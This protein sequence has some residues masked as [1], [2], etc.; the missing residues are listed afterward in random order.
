MR[1]IPN[2][3]CQV[4]QGSDAADFLGGKG[5]KKTDIVILGSS[6]YEQPGM[7]DYIDR[8]CLSSVCIVHRN[9]VK[10]EYV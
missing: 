3:A 5:L 8:T 10:Q 2:V 1:T 7:K 4:V 9:A 6:M